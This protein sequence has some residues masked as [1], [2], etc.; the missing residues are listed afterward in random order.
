MRRLLRDLI[1]STPTVWEMSLESLFLPLLLTAS[2]LTL[3][4]NLW[5]FF[6]YGK[7]GDEQTGTTSA[8]GKPRVRR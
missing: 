5:V 1:T 2:T 7:S 3:I 8:T 4:V 6:A